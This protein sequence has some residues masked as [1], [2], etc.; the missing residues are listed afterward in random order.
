MAGLIEY[1]EGESYVRIIGWFHKRSGPDNPNRVDSV[2]SDLSRLDDV[3]PQMLC[4][5][6][7]ELASSAVRRSLRWKQQGAGREQLYRSLKQLLGETYQ[8]HGDAFLE[9]LRDE[10]VGLPGAV[11]TEIHAIFPPLIISSMTLDEKPSGRVPPTLLEH[12]T[13]RDVDE[14]EMKTKKDLEETAQIPRFAVSEVQRLDEPLDTL[15]KREGPTVA[16]INS[17]LAKQAM[18]A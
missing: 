16:T 17:S 3:H 11:A 14:T 15:R 13:R 6:V 1:D 10:L 2:I 8:D 18:Q 12:E 9:C 5:A 7:S 4:R